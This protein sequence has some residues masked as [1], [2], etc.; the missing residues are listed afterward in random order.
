MSQ[1]DLPE[2]YEPN[3]LLGAVL[4]RLFA[5]IEV[6]P[7]W[8]PLQRSAAQDK[9]VVHVLP[10]VNFLE[11]LALDQITKRHALPRIRF[12]NDL[13]LWVLNPMGKGWLNALMPWRAPEPVDELRSAIENG[14]SAALFLK[15]RANVVDVA[16]SG[17]RI[18]ETEPKE[19]DRLV[20]AL[21][22]LQRRSERPILLVPELFVW[23]KQPERDAPRARDLVL[24]PP[25]SPNAAWAIAHLLA[26]QGARLRA[27]EP[28]NLKDFLS[29]HDGLPP[30]TL[31]R[32]LVYAMLR[33]FSRERRTV[34]GPA[35][36]AAERVRAEIAR[37]LRLREL[38]D[39]LAAGDPAVASKLRARVLEILNKL[40]ATPEHY[41]MRTMGWSVHWLFQWLYA[42]IEVDR[43]DVERIRQAAREGALI[44]LPSHKSHFDYLVLGHQFDKLDLPLPMIAAGDNL[45][46]FPMGPLFRRS[47]AFFI[48]RTFRG[49]RLYA[50]VVDAYIRRLIR[51]GFA[52]ELYLEGGRSRTGKLLPPKLGL[53]SMIVDASLAES[54]RKT[55]FVPIS[56]GY[57]RI[58]ESD[59]YHRELTGGEKNKEDAASLLRS[60]RVLRY[61]YGRINL[62]FG[63]IFD[64]DEARRQIGIEESEELKPARRRALVASV[65]RRVMDEINRITAVTPGALT[66]LALLSHSHRGLAHEDL[67]ERAGRLLLLLKRSGARYT[68][69]T[70]TPAGTLRPE[71]LR[72]AVQLFADGELVEVHFT[73]ET[74]TARRRRRAGK[75]VAGPGAFYTVPDGKRLALDTSK[76]IIIHFFV[77][78]ALLALAV[79]SPQGT[80]PTEAE[81]LQRF[82]ETCRLFEHEFQ[83]PTSQ[84]DADAGRAVLAEA[85]DLGILEGTADGR[86]RPGAGCDGASAPQWLNLL[87]AIIVNYVEGYRICARALALL[88]GG[89]LSEK[90]F[91]KGALAIGHRMY[92]AGEVSRR[93]SISNP[94]LRNALRAFSGYGGVVLLGDQV[95]LTP[96]FQ[97]ERGYIAFEER[98]ASLLKGVTS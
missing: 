73:A 2:P 29:N 62:Q 61:R 55:S 13:G 23:S 34:I 54:Q 88:D 11:F 16:T 91:S 96:Q 53:L 9:T 27:A 3:P 94:I 70:A 32:K 33:R 7:T 87:A 80:P 5:S 6:D 81:V 25:E 67:V 44:L 46:F 58:V 71:A 66:A 75:A 90:E 18:R 78:R 15:K 43:G 22:E 79:L 92:F 95:Q 47:G 85:L 12:V 1:P 42:G 26:S 93:E 50:A 48:R 24:G 76:N 63:E 72:E 60:R 77:Q 65:A 31:V 52:I 74:P 83:L 69:A 86:L 98:I 49:D 37:S 97:Q 64:L 39:D 21:F 8:L 59:S 35:V 41:T 19:G 45:D 20:R 56:I 36:K 89:P 82:N 4:D 30:E 68:S 28:L 40:Q 17:A 57:E 10:S 14:G 51:D 38:V 84:N